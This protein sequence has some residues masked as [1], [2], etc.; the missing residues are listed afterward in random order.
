MPA[1]LTRATLVAALIGCGAIPVHGQGIEPLHKTDLMQLLAGGT[2]SPAE[3]AALIRRNCLAFTPTAR[4]RNDLIDLGADTAVLA[5][6]DACA[7][8]PRATPP[9]AGPAPRPQATPA[10]PA[11]APE[12][13]GFVAGVGQRGV[14]GDTARAPL[15]FEVRDGSGRPIAN[16]PVSVT[17]E[18]ARLLPRAERTDLQGR[19][20]VRLVFGTAAGRTLVR[21]A[22]GTVLRTAV[23]YAQPGPPRRFA[24]AGA[25]GARADSVALRAD[26]VAVV[27]IVALDAWGNP[28]P[29]AG[30]DARVDDE[31]VARIARATWDSTGAALEIAA[32]R[33]GRTALRLAIPGLAGELSLTVVRRR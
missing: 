27:R 22:A 3:I 8:R 1:S 2:L 13:T 30:F 18:N 9:A 15:V 7:A 21:A 32:R 17:A 19:V 23:L 28:V 14:V 4:D 29:P 31:R 6:I 26:S 12:H 24:V 20:V 11:P 5:S 10:P 33:P 25:G 16:A